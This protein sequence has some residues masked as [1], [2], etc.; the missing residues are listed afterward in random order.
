MIELRDVRRALGGTPVLRGVRLAVA[1]G[2]RVA[3]VGPSGAGK[4]SLF[5]VLNLTLRPDG[6]TY[7]LDGRDTS[8][9]R[10]EE[11]RRARAGI[12]TIHQLH[13]VVHRLTAL[14]NVLAGRLGRWGALEA[15]RARFAPRQEDVDA[16]AEALRRVDLLAKAL[17]RTDRL[18]GGEQQRVAIARAFFQEASVILADEPVAS[19]DPGLQEGIVR[20]LVEASQ[21]DGR[22]VVV[23][24][25]HPHLARRF[26]P[27]IVALRDGAV[28]FDVPSE[29]AGDARLAELF[30]GDA[31]PTWTPGAPEEPG[32]P[33][34]VRP[35][36]RPTDVRL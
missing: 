35:A 9:L 1:R 10:G 14:E 21:R 3:V 19:V 34:A 28:A 24:L 8:R 15:L 25:H 20:L 13:D 7:E 17:V 4:T 18:S 22:T 27:R 36:C 5:R 16:A 33:R 23:S 11:R 29:E 2:E 32:V 30:A 12:A 26:F 31:G 6:G